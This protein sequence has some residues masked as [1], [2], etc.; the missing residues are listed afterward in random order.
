MFKKLL[1][2]I[3]ICCFAIY[4]NKDRLDKIFQTRQDEN[5]TYLFT[6]QELKQYDGID[7]PE[8]FL[9]ILGN[10][11][12]VTKGAEHY[13]PAKTYHSFIG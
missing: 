13:G 3:I 7:K 4:F 1:V 6:S 9:V 11:Y 10:V 5:G 2:S 8:L 12:N